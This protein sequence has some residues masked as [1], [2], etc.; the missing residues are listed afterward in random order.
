MGGM[1][2]GHSHGMP[3]AGAGQARQGN[4]PGSIRVTPEE[5]EAIQRLQ[6]LGFSQGRAAQAYFACDKNEEFAA[7]FLFESVAEEEE[8][9]VQEGIANSQGLSLAAQAN[10][11]QQQPAQQQ[12]AQQQP[13]QQQPGAGANQPGANNNQNN[14]NDGQ[15]PSG[16]AG[17]G[18]ETSSFQ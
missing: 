10:P 13:A 11:A 3:G 4:P 17:A 14:N 6:S 12:P 7:N 15:D 5:M 2:G 1:G 8:S 9:F 16:D 18:G